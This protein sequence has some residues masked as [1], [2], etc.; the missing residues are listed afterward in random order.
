M[1]TF[2][3][4]DIHGHR[5]ALQALLAA[6]PL[7]DED[8]LILLGDYVDKGPDVR[9][10]LDLLSELSRRPNTISLRGNHDQMLIDAYR[11]PA[12]F[13]IWECLAGKNPLA[14]YGEGSVDE[15]LHLIPDHHWAFLEQACV[16][17][18]ETEKFIFVHGGIRPSFSPAEEDL[19]RLQWTS[20]SMALPHDSGKTVVCGHTRNEWG[21]I[22]D[23]G[24]TICVDTGISHD[25]RLTCLELESFEFWQADQEG[26][27]TE[28]R[29]QR[30][31]R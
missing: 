30:D 20:L 7:R 27:V 21:R 5:R 10:V 12:K 3:I 25:G 16:D 2:V 11:E 15:V 24:H 13:A 8:Q 6:I 23:L 17:W 28:G 19:E 9:G 31:V 26:V 18:H 22:T 1:K 4:G 14:G 29:L